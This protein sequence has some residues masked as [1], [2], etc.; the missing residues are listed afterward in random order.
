MS[1]EIRGLRATEMEAHAALVHQSYYEYVVSGERQFLADPHWWLKAAGADPYYDPALTRV[2]LID[3]QMVASVTSY[4]RLVYVAD[5][6]RA[7]VGSIGSVCTHPDFRRRGLVKLVLEDSIA[8]MADN[9]FHWSS[10]FG[11]ETVYNSSGWTVLSSFNCTAQVGLREEYGPLTAQPA[12]TEADAA[13]L[14]QV[15]EAF[16]GR[17]TGPVVRNA[18]YWRNVVLAGRWGAPPVYYLLRRG[19]E[20]VGYYC[21]EGGKL[22][23]VGWTQPGH[24][25]VAFLLRLAAGEPVS[26]PFATA[27]LTQLL[28]EISYAP[29]A[30]AAQASITLNEAYKGL[31]RYIG[32]GGGEFPE[33][34]DTESM[35]RF[36]RDREYAYWG[37]D[38]Y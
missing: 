11:K 33:I 21:G 7:R 28:R 4:D 38:G 27:E 37:A 9:G 8:F 12:Q 30:E 35:K 16:S 31:W 20:T 13:E 6:R 19:S 14:A 34:T 18:A 24:D 29:C 3:G 5:G 17:L 25:V 36:L 32:P 26:F 2:M 1:T 10:L 15:Y 22:R 23:E